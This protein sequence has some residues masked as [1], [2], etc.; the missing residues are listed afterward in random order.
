MK[1][2]HSRFV[3]EWRVTP[4]V[5][6]L[7]AKVAYVKVTEWNLITWDST[8]EVRWRTCQL[9]WLAAQRI[10]VVSLPV[11]NHLLHK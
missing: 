6:K 5:A 7:Y 11:I 10:D 2:V 3:E 8:V 9:V 4:H 1:T